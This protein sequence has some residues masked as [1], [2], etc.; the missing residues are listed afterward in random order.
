M[1]LAL[2]TKFQVQLRA[3][4]YLLA[5]VLL[6]AG[7]LA[8]PSEIPR[9]WRLSGS[10]SGHIQAQQDLFFGSAQIAISAKNMET[11]YGAHCVGILE[12]IDATTG[13]FCQ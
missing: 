8:N 11:I 13:N 5:G 10:I 2:L 6:G 1:A 3:I 9:C 4:P 7:C 12:N